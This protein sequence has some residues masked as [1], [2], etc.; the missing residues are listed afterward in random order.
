[1][2][3]ER[4]MGIVKTNRL[5]FPA[6]LLAVGLALVATPALSQGVVDSA[7]AFPTEFGRQKAQTPGDL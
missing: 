1:M 2:W 7:V 5:E 6:A 3:G 4:T